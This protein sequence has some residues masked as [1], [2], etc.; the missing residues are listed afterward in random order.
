MASGLAKRLK[1]LRTERGLTQAALAKRA[2]VTLSYVGRLEI[3][4]HD[5]QLS[6]LRKLARALKV[7]VGALID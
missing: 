5:P 3:G 7:K 4:M 1:Q 6:S 2:G